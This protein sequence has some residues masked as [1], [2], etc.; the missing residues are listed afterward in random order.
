MYLSR[1]IFLLHPSRSLAPSCLALP[2][3]T[4]ALPRSR[5]QTNTPDARPTAHA[6]VPVGHAHTPH[7]PNIDS[8][9]ITEQLFL[10]FLFFSLLALFIS[11]VAQIYSTPIWTFQHFKHRL[12]DFT[13]AT[14]HGLQPS[15]NGLHLHLHLSRTALPSTPARRPSAPEPQPAGKPPASDIFRTR[16]T[17]T[18]SCPLA[19]LSSTCPLHYPALD[20]FYLLS[21]FAT[22]FFCDLAPTLHTTKTL[23]AARVTAPLSPRLDSRPPADCLHTNLVRPSAPIQARADT[24]Q[25]HRATIITPLCVFEISIGGDDIESVHQPHFCCITSHPALPAQLQAKGKRK[26]ENTPDRV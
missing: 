20:Q 7:L 6:S 26:T 3:R 13:T 14:R 11:P 1:S 8:R 17:A 9:G 22:V 21:R 19:S 10:D 2:Q 12:L 25:Q 24:V 4:R 15:R 5:L 16:L 23:P 18:G